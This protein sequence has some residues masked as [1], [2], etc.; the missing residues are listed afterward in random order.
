MG[1]T[2]GYHVQGSKGKNL[3]TPLVCL[4][5]NFIKF[6]VV[7]EASRISYYDWQQSIGVIWN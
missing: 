5:K 4:A 3:P 2:L 6:G 1:P 7:K